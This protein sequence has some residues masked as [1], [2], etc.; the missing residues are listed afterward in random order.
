LYIGM[1]LDTDNQARQYVQNYAIH[2]NFAVKNGQVGNKATT[3]LLVCKCANKFDPGKLPLEKG[4][5]GNNGLIRQKEAR[6]MLCDCPWKVRFKKQLNDTWIATQLIDEH[7]GHHL[8][9][10]S[11]FAYPENRQPTPAATEVMNDLARNSSA[12]R[13]TIATFLNTTF[14]LHL[15]GRDVSNHTYDYT[16]NNGSSTAKFIQNLEENGWIYRLR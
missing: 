14:D 5:L 7:K 15:L 8:E 16:K 3:L 1:V 2:H 11:A 13:T 12:P 6:T 10:I 9:G 4:V